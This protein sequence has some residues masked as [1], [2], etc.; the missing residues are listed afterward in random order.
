MEE[1]LI[2]VAGTIIALAGTVIA[3]AQLYLANLKQKDALFGRRAE[4]VSAVQNTYGM[5]TSNQQG[6]IYEA[7]NKARDNG[8]YLFPADVIKALCDLMTVCTNLATLK[9]RRNDSNVHSDHDRWNENHDKI[10]QLEKGRLSA[11]HHFDTLAL[12]HLNMAETF[13]DWFAH[14]LQQVGSRSMRKRTAS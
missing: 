9:D 3:L 13:G 1:L 10:E 14:G 7:L 12:P 6:E 8:Q 5:D 11:Q 2:G 4:I